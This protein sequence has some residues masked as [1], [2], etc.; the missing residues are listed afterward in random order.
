MMKLKLDIDS[1][2]I[3]ER[4]QNVKLNS[5]LNIHLILLCAL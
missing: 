5:S 2:Q 3:Y 1:I 4:A